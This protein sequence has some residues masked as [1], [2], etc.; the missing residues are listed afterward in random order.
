METQRTRAARALIGR[1]VGVLFFCGSGALWMLTSLHA[2]GR[3]TQISG[4]L[5]GL[6]AVSLFTGAWRLS[7]R[8]E[9]VAGPELTERN[10]ADQWRGGRL[11]GRMSRS[12]W[13]FR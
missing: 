10:A 6:A 1:S 12:G 8:M 4:A 5:V 13:R 11:C 9:R 7:A 2:L 3:L